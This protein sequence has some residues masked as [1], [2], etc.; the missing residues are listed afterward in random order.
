MDYS[1]GLQASVRNNKPVAVVIGRGNQ[2]WETLSQDGKLDLETRQLLMANYVCVYVDVSKDQGLANA[3]AID[4]PGI[5]ISST[6]GR[7]QAFRHEGKLANDNLVAYLKKFSDP[8]REVTTT[9]GSRP[10]A[11]YY[12]QGPV[13]TAPVCRT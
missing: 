8:E 6:G 7:L 2:G 5:V 13:Q 4:G 1:D 12:P 3:F 11:S 10:R 9:E